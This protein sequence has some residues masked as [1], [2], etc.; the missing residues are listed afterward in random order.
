MESFMFICLIM[1]LIPWVIGTLLISVDDHFNWET[2]GNWQLCD[3]IEPEKKKLS[4]R[5][6]GEGKISLKRQRGPFCTD[7]PISFY[8]GSTFPPL[9]K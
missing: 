2:S 6:Q 1:L 3:A 8:R 9:E 5:L 4:Q 7:S